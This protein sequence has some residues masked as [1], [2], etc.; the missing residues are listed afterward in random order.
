M[1]TLL[2]YL[3]QGNLKKSKNVDKNSYYWRKKSSYFWTSWV[4]SIKLPRKVCL[5]IILKVKKKQGFTHTLKYIVL[6][7]PA[8]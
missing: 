6:E 3:Q 8:F 7:K 4:T 1:L 5:T 2:V